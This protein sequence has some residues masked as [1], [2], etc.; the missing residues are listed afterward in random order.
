MPAFERGPITGTLS[1]VC[2][3]PRLAVSRLT[4]AL[5]VLP[6]TKRMPWTHSDLSLGT[7]A[8]SCVGPSAWCQHSPTKL[9]PILRQLWRSSFLS[10]VH[11]LYVSGKISIMSL[12]IDLG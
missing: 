9:N 8:M 3:L 12:L 4:T 10:V 11:V 2:L 6:S 7:I 1:R 5:T